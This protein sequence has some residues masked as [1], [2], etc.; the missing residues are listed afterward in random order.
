MDEEKVRV[1]KEHIKLM[2]E[3]LS[4]IPKRFIDEDTTHIDWQWNDELTIIIANPKY[5]PMCYKKGRWH[6]I[7][8]LVPGS[9]GVISIN[10][11]MPIFKKD[12][13]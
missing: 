11:P 12:R 8:Y 1:S 7:A 13:R 5:A 10:Q 3:A 4:K 9:I 6:K 2:Y